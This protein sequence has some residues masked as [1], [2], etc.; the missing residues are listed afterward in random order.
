MESPALRPHQLLESLCTPPCFCAPAGGGH[1]APPGKTVCYF[2][3]ATVAFKVL[4][5]SFTRISAGDWRGSRKTGLGPRGFWPLQPLPVQEKEGPRREVAVS[6]GRVLWLSWSRSLAL[7]LINRGQASRPC[8]SQGTGEEG[9][10]RCESVADNKAECARTDASPVFFHGF[11]PGPQHWGSQPCVGRCPREERRPGPG[12]GG[13]TGI[14]PAR[15]PWASQGCSSFSCR[16]VPSVPHGLSGPRGAAA[17]GRTRGSLVQTQPPVE[18]EEGPRQAALR[19]FLP[20]RFLQRAAVLTWDN[21]AG[22]GVS[23][24][25][26]VPG[27]ADG[28]GAAQ[29]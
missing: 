22:G 12:V 28:S 3:K 25:P 1:T 7:A 2:L 27:V 9:S 24:T 10:S 13:C 21:V 15:D 4:I 6:Q 20:G 19:P 14:S 11:S 26:V 16:L 5:N 17:Q 18:G 23:S 29:P 8:P